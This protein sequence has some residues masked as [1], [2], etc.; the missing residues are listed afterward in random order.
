MLKDFDSPELKIPITSYGSIPVFTGVNKLYKG[1]IESSTNFLPLSSEFNKKQFKQ[2]SRPPEF[3][4][5]PL[6]LTQRRQFGPNSDPRAPEA[7]IL[8][9]IGAKMP[10]FW[11][12][13][14][15]RSGQDLNLAARPLLALFGGKS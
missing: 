12:K 7:P 1:T 2:S 6:K 11:P 3:A 9:K 15:C 14:A 8:A 10:L 13:T 4:I 5:L